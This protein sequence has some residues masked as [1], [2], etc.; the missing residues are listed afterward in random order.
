MTAK[1][2]NIDE[3]RTEKEREQIV[4]K[5]NEYYRQLREQGWIVCAPDKDA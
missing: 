3:K 4:A 2:I 1:V 5:I